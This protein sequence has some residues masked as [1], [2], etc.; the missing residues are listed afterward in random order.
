MIETEQQRRWW[1]A[2]HPEFSSNRPNY[3]AQAEGIDA[4]V[5]ERLKYEADSKII[6]LLN[7]IGQI[8]GSQSDFARLGDDPYDDWDNE[9][10]GK[11]RPPRPGTRP[12]SRGRRGLE[13][14]DWIHMS[15]AE[16]EARSIIEAELEKAGTNPRYYELTTFA[17]RFIARRRDIYDPDQLDDQGRTNDQRILLKRSPMDRDGKAIALHHANQR[18]EGPFIEMT[19]AEH[20]QIVSREPSRIDRTDF[21]DFREMYWLARM[22]SI[23]RPDPD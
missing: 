13:I 17:G 12:S 10:G 23:R 9:A 5:K 1:F 21:R 20:R 16:R 3:R 22:A 14:S 8:F 18:P 4:Y 2:T 6:D 19:D 11:V 15:R 7:L